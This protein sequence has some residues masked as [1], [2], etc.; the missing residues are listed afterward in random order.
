[1]IIFLYTIMILLMGNL[2]I[3]P[4]IYW[5]SAVHLP[6]L[7]AGIAIGEMQPDPL[8]TLTV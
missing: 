6:A 8:N 7:H 1:M 2:I 3:I 4:Y 5:L